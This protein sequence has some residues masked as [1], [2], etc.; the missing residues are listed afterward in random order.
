MTWPVNQA[1]QSY[2]TFQV[3]FINFFLNFGGGG[4]F[5]LLRPYEIT[6]EKPISG[7]RLDECI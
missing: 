6:I 3:F 4:V 2:Q 1:R 5:S 7:R